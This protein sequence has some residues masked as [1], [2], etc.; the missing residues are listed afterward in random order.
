M[1]SWSHFM[2]IFSIPGYNS[3]WVCVIPVFSI[4]WRILLKWFL[5]LLVLKN[6]FFLYGPTPSS[7]K[8]AMETLMKFDWHYSV[9][10]WLTLPGNQKLKQAKVKL[11]D[12]E[13]CKNIWKEEK[14]MNARRP[15]LAKNV[16]AGPPHI[17]EVV[18][19]II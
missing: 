18:Y 7:S 3:E 11:Y 4:Q 19:W 6:S 17:F 15:I 9:K 12:F 14:V 5:S 16:C 1:I 10:Q 8:F 2:H 13:E